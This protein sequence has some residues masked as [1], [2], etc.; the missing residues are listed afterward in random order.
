[1]I[2][3][4]RRVQYHLLLPQCSMITQ[5]NRLFLFVGRGVESVDCNHSDP[6][7]IDNDPSDVRCADAAV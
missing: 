7:I 4:L 2:D 1:M 3:D 6:D 5:S